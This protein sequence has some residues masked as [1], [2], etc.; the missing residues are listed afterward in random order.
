VAGIRQR[1]KAQRPTQILEAAFAEFSDK[2]YGSARVEDVARRIGVTKGTIYF[3]FPSKEELFKATCRAHLLPFFDRLERLPEEIPGTAADLLLGILDV[4]YDD[5]V[6]D[7]RSSEFLRLMIGEASRVPELVEFYSSELIDR[8][9]GALRAVLE[10]GVRTG[11]FRPDAA[12]LFA[13]SPEMIIGP[14]VMAVLNG[15]MFGQPE[16]KDVERL[17]EAH[18]ALLLDGLRV[19]SA[20]P[21]ER[22]RRSR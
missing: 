9:N 12:R 21:P 10:R 11:E 1:T 22:P 5:W 19:R 20:D 4:A 8:G 6:A 2:G 13:E 17:K 7:H 3:Y 15:I 18:L 14:S 16:V